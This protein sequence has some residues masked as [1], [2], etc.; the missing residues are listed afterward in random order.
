ME[1]NIPKYVY[2]TCTFQNTI[3]NSFDNCNTTK[4]LIKF[5]Y[6]VYR[7]TPVQPSTE[8]TRTDTLNSEPFFIFDGTCNKTQSQTNC[9]PSTNC[10]ICRRKPLPSYILLLSTCA[11]TSSVHY[12]PVIDRMCEKAVPHPYP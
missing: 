6:F 12:L 7:N 10:H 4:T 9:H 8:C 5:N 3:M 1:F 11:L 2:N